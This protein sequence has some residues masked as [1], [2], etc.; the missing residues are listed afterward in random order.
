MQVNTTESERWGAAITLPAEQEAEGF[1][2][3]LFYVVP[4]E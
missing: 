4:D 1:V 2:V 3:F